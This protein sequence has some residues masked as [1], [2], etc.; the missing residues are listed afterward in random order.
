[1]NNNS[2]FEFY[3]G[4]MGAGKTREIFKVLHSMKEDGFYPIILKP[5]TDTKGDNSI[6]SRDGASI[7]VDFLIGEE[8][9]IYQII[10]MYW[11]DHHLDSILV[12]EAEFLTSDQ[13]KQLTMIVD[14]L[15]I[16]VICY[17]LLT[18]FQGKL[19]E[20]SKALIEWDA[21][22]IEIKRQCKCGNKKAFNMRLINDIPVFEGEQVAIDGKDA[23]YESVCR[24][25]Y[26]KMEVTYRNKKLTLKK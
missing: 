22:L 19:F 21:K 23:K 10:A 7:D 9:N 5:R 25:C 6:V 13:V 16:D 8:D 15:R 1:M 24:Q 11:S 20:G 18:D 14:K 26:K 12:D 17:G 3:Y 4:A 2:K